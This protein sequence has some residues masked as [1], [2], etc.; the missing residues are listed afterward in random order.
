MPGVPRCRIDDRDE[1]AMI[2]FRPLIR[3]ADFKGRASRAEYWLF[4]IFQA[5]WYGF[6]V[7]LAAVAAG[8]AD[9]A[10]VAPGVL[11][12]LALIGVSVVGLIVPNYSVLVRRLHDTGRGAV[13]LVLLAPG[14]AS[15]FL[16]CVTLGTA[17]GS[18]GLG[19]GREVFVGTILAGLGTAG[20]LGL[21]GMLGQ[22]VMGVLMLL[23]GTRGENRFG[24][25][26]RDPAARYSSGGGGG[27][28]YDDARLEALFAEARRANAAREDPGRPVFD[29]GPGPTP[30]APS[31]WHAPAPGTAP[32]PT[33]GRRGT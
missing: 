18:V 31:G 5:V 29:F 22:M 25:D 17:A 1:R 10:G 21:V 6:L 8:Q 32:A 33:F 26:P 4:A 24:P 20:L 15:A 23:P 16:T 28:V 27:T 3:Y 12:A 13:W 30:I 19:A 2:L 7:A 9:T 11:V 14:L